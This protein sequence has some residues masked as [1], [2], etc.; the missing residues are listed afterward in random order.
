MKLASLPQQTLSAAV[1]ESLSGPSLHTWRHTI[2]VAIG[3]ERTWLDLQL[4][5]SGRE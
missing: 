5:R 3:A 1:H 4:F 2:S